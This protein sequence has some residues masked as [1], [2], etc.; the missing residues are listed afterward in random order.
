MKPRKKIVK[1]EENDLG[2][3]SKP[4]IDPFF[5]KY[6]YYENI[7]AIVFA[8]VILG[9]TIYNR[10]DYANI[11]FGIIGILLCLAVVIV[12]VVNAKV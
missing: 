1:E 5:K 9:W 8:L 3:E 4:Y 7:I 12:N 6:F 2:F 10:Y 11:I